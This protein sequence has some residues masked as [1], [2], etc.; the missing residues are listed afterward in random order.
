MLVLIEIVLLHDCVNVCDFH[1]FFVVSAV[2]G[3]VV[4]LA[5]MFL[6]CRLNSSDF[7]IP[8]VA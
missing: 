1:F 7:L 5:M 8:K 4:A 3:F 6:D 2:A